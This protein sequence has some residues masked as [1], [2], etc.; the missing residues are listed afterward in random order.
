MGLMTILLPALLTGFVASREG[1]PQR[2]NRLYATALIK[3]AE[4]ALRVTRNTNWSAISGGGV[5]H[6]VDS[7]TNW[8]I[9]PGTETVATYYTRQILIEDI[10]R[11]SNGNIVT[12]GGTADPSTK[13]A[14]I[15]VSWTQPKN[16]YLQS[17]VYLTR[18]VNNTTVT[19]TT[20][21]DF[22]A[23]TTNNVDVVSTGD[24]AVRL[25]TPT[26]ALSSTDDYTT[27]SNY[28]YDSAK[29]EFVG[30]YAQLKSTVGV[31][32]S[33]TNPDFTTALTPW[34][35]SSYNDSPAPTF[36]RVATGGNPGAYGRITFTTTRNK[37]ISGYMLQ[38]FT[39]ANAGSTGLFSFDKRVTSYSAT[40]LDFR[41]RVYVDQTNGT[42]TNLVWDSGNIVATSAWSSTLNLDVSPFISAPSTYYLKVGGYVTYPVS[43]NRGPYAIAFDNVKLSWTAPSNNYPTDSPPVTWNSSLAPSNLIAWT[44]FSAVEVLNGGSI[45]YQLSNDDG[46]SWLY[47]DGSAW[48]TASGT[49]G[50]SASNINSN[51]ATFPLG[52]NSIRVRALLVSNGT[53]LVKLDSVTLNYSSGSGSSSG[54]FTSSTI[55]AGSP[56]SFNRITWDDVN[57]G[58]T[59]TQFQIATNNDNSTWSFVGPDGTASTY[60]TSN[61]GKINLL[62]IAGRYCRYKVYFT[63][64]NTDLPYV[65]KVVVNYS[66]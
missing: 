29:I 36:A 21:S 28:S 25:V 3:E 7:G 17:V 45:K 65:S 57:T 22:L 18:F 1:K 46:S 52:N 20:Q 15:T 14:T 11:D 5:Y 38:S 53:Q 49:L 35:L 2:E 31:S 32:G 10:Q 59:T 64:T 50:T 63:T 40:P 54:T 55:D 4:E 24:G 41:I 13:K 6:P 58:N 34:T 9:V 51:I 12:S 48:T 39:V 30:G 16:D 56:A 23:G 47:H 27:A 62:N 26:Q 61:E 66:P 8:S 37:T 19:H 43:T 33:T 44:G 42:P 60:F